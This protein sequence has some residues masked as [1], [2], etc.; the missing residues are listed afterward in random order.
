MELFVPEAS[1]TM[2]MLIP[3][4]TKVLPLPDCISFEP[5]VGILAPASEKD[6]ETRLWNE[7]PKLFHYISYLPSTDDRPRWLHV[8]KRTGENHRH[9]FL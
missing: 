5:R 1:S 8:F 6:R 7:Q 2:V 4:V 9:L 3:V